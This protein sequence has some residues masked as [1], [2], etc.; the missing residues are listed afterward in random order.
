MDQLIQLTIHIRT[1]SFNGVKEMLQNKNLNINQYV[2]ESINVY[3]TPLHDAIISGVIEIIQLLIE[4]NADINLRNSH[5]ITPI[6]LAIMNNN[7]ELT[8]YM[9]YK[10][11]K[12]EYDN[13]Y[14]NYAINNNNYAMVALLIDTKFNY[15][16]SN[17]LN[18]A[19]QKNNSEIVTL[20]LDSGCN[21]DTNSIFY[22][23]HNL[24]I[25]YG[26]SLNY[27]S[28]DIL[29]MICN[30]NYNSKVKNING[31]HPIHYFANIICT[32]NQ[33]FMNKQSMMLASILYNFVKN[34]PYDLFLLKNNK[35]KS[36]F[37]C[38]AELNPSMLNVFIPYIMDKC[39]TNKEF[40]EYITIAT[41]MCNMN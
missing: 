29:T 6:G 2:Y 25:P 36:F 39:K 3:T 10:S 8:K 11:K 20:L 19:I 17:I 7:F 33:E 18:L 15:N 4:N 23:I 22:A 21:L 26:L 32:F 14:F 9:L 24:T 41:T 28:V 1:K 5:N 34:N 37:A 27:T 31:E 13:S 38:I 40:I 16:D 12:I 35:N 30:N